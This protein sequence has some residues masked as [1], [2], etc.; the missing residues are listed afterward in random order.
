MFLKLKKKI[1]EAISAAAGVPL[2]EAE[3]SVELPKGQF[4]DVAT[5]ICFLL[6]KREKKSPVAL[7][8]QI[9]AKLRLP[10]WVSEAKTVGPYI[11]FF[12]SDGFYAALVG[13][14]GKEGAAFGKGS[15]RS[16]K[17]IIE[18][19]SVNPNK[20][21]HIGH[22]RN[23]LLGDS[24]ARVLEFSGE[25]VERTDYID[26]LGLQ[27]AQSFWG[28]LH[29]GKK[30]SGKLD[31]WLGGEYVEAA[32]RFEESENVQKEVRALV[33]EMEDGE[34]ENARACRRLVE[35]CVAA[36]YETAF[37][38]S[39]YHDVMIFESD[40]LHT[41]FE[42]GM[43]RLKENPAI[44]KE[45]EGK[46]A[47]CLVAKMASPEFASMESPDK[48]LV[49]SD[50]TATYTGKDVIFQLWKFNLLKSDFAYTDFMVQPNGRPCMMTA[51]DGKGMGFGKAARVINVIG[52][53]QA[54]PQKVIREIL[55]SMGYRHEAESSVHL[56]YEHVGLED[57]KFS[58][59]QGT[60]MGFTTD[61]L[62][63]E[64]VKRAEAK[65]KPDVVG[66]ERAKI[67][68]AIAAAAIRFTM[69]RT[70]PEKRITFRWDDA[71]SLEGDSAP[72]AIYAHARA[73]KISEK[74]GK[75]KAGIAFEPAEKELLKKVMLLDFVVAE[76]ARQL[77][78]HI[79]AEYCLDLAALYN[80]FYNSCPILSCED[81]GAKQ[82]RL[83]SNY[84]AKVAMKN[85][86]GAIGIPALERM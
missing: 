82:S 69:I 6:A 78:P 2:E 49:R 31:L 29:L 80:K 73:H 66:G 12:L 44:V 83:A 8:G 47:G 57:A 38:F 62:Y 15:A 37:K 7:A 14:A 20:P 74:G 30:P 18:F 53:E 35:K 9:C 5:S 34:G 21:W 28:Y 1:A 40:I 3:A 63:D 48:I 42:E 50:G 52:M 72:Y 67:A 36:Q 56:S 54:Y 17:T 65:I 75:G 13:E 86:L 79:V 19:P 16:G 85:A 76:S 55:L 81:E 61:E 32:K 22:L 51:R 45:T 64:G 27:V 23:A 60:W 4:G 58:G 59:R 46:N 11:N 41:I 10:E 25:S 68:A 70:T 71:L 33:K 26:D 84:A 24:V 39:I 77:R 43:G